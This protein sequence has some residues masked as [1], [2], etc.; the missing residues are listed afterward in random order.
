MESHFWRY[1]IILIVLYIFW[2]NF[3][4]ARGLLNQL[5]FNFA[6]FYPLGFLV[7]YRSNLENLGTAY[8]SAFLF[9]SLSYVLAM[10]EGVLIQGWKIIIV[11]YLSVL[12]ILEIGRIIGKHANHS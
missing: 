7:G 9:N 4:D 12:I 10:S 5:V 8:F 1:Q 2:S 3:F 6:L 11:D